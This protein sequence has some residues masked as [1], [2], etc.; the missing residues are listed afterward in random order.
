MFT[1]VL[2]F[3]F[4]PWP[5]FF[6]RIVSNWKSTV[7]GRRVFRTSG[8]REPGTADPRENFV[9]P[10][11]G[12]LACLRGGVHHVFALLRSGDQGVAE[13]PVGPMWL[14]RANGLRTGFWSRFL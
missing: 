9:S 13:G 5:Y 12:T 10:G 3:G 2:Q 7:R 14:E 4:W 1:F 11:D 6:Q 8:R